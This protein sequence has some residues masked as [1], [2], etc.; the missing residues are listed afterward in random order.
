MWT[1]QFAKMQHLAEMR[2]WTKFVSQQNCYNLLYR[3]EEREMNPFC[4]DSG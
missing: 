3:E 1:W 2:G 4:L